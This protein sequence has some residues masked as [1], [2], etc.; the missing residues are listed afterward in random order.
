[1]ARSPLRHRKTAWS[2]DDKPS[3]P[4]SPPGQPP[5]GA[6]APMVY[7]PSVNLEDAVKWPLEIPGKLD[8][9]KMEV[10]EGNVNVHL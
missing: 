7:K 6:V 2:M 5:V 1:M 9:R 3:P 8:F 10:F 4:T